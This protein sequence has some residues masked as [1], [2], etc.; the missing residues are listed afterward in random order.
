M[1]DDGVP[2]NVDFLISDIFCLQALE[3]LDVMKLY[4]MVI[5]L[6]PMFAL[7]ERMMS[8]SEDD[9]V[10]NAVM[11]NCLIDGFCKASELN[12]TKELFD[13]MSKNR[14]EWNMISQQRKIHNIKPSTT[15][16]ST[17]TKTIHPPSRPSPP[18]INHL[19]RPIIRRGRGS[20]ATPHCTT[21]SS[22]TTIRLHNLANIN[23]KPH[24]P[25]SESAPSPRYHRQTQPVCSKLTAIGPV[26]SGL[27]E[28][29]AVRDGRVRRC[30]VERHDSWRGEA[31]AC[32]RRFG[33]E[34]RGSWR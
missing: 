14:V 30:E 27:K 6:L 22:I 25:Y 3:W 17:I 31:K 16:K 11:Y 29:E 19:H 20:S 21:N 4:T 18:S 24:L 26:L 5:F 8:G 2:P 13:L 23:H 10:P 1:E 34:R 7:M 15:P 33:A 28:E 12:K 32:A 9:C